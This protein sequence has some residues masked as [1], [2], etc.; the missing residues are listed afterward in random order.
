M[1]PDLALLSTLI[2]SN[3][4]C[5]ELV[6]IVFEPLKFDC[7]NKLGSMITT[8][9]IAVTDTA[10]EVLGKEG[11][12]KSPGSPEI[13]SRICR[14]GYKAEGVKEY[15]HA[16]KRVQKTLKKVKED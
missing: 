2:G 12:R 7:N 6:F 1:P 15:R 10:S 9:N 3:Y 13:F 11:R 16:I 8:Y 4:P 14:R 5:L